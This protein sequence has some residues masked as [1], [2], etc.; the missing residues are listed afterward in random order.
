MSIVLDLIPSVESHNELTTSQE[1]GVKPASGK[2]LACEILAKE[3]FLS[4][5]KMHIGSRELA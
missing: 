4:F 1:F 2:P 3:V 5:K